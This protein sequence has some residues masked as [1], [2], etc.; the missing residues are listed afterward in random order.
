[1]AYQTLQK[2]KVYYQNLQL[3]KL[4]SQVQDKLNFSFGPYKK[5][6]SFVNAH[7]CLKGINEMYKIAKRYMSI[8]C[9]SINLLTICSEYLTAI[10]GKI[11]DLESNSKRLIDFLRSCMTLYG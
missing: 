8:G 6:S 3:S 10:E 9:R 1:M 5:T 11:V 7:K 2:D 4:N